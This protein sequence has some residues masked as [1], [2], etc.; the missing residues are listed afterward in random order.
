MAVEA[1]PGTPSRIL[2]AD[3]HPVVRQGI[4]AIISQE[5]DMTVVAQAGSG[6]E[7][8]DLFRRHRPDL[9][10]MDLSLPDR[11][12]V[13][14]IETLLAESPDARFVVLT[15]YGGEDDIYLALK[16]GARAYLLKD[17]GGEVLVEAIRAVLE[18]KRYLP[19]GVA[20]RL[21]DRMSGTDL[22]RRELDV[23]KLLAA[24]GS[25]RRIAERLHV[26]EGTVKTHLNNILGKLGVTSRTQAILT[27]LRRGIVRERE[28]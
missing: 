11:T 20:S 7:A 5:P 22:T 13:E 2:I 6:A 24:G 10:L 4:A 21:A 28:P 15:V 1:A 18:G 23:L 17:A 3:D 9:T 27:A 19:P 12:G 25:N 16:A 14:V 8:I 26:T